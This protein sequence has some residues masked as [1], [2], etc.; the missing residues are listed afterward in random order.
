MQDQPNP[1][2]LYTNNYN[3]MNSTQN[4]NLT[5]SHVA[6]NN[7]SP[8]TP[9][10]PI[11]ASFDGLHHGGAQSEDDFW[12]F[13]D[14]LLSSLLD[15]RNLGQDDGGVCLM[16]QDGGRSGGE[17]ENHD[18]AGR[19]NSRLLEEGG[20]GVSLMDQILGQSDEGGGGANLMEQGG[21]GGGELENYNNVDHGKSGLLEG[22]SERNEKNKKRGVPRYNLAEIWPEDPDRAKRLLE[23]RQYMAR[24]R[25]KKVRYV[26]ELE[27]KAQ[28]LEFEATNLSAQLITY[29][30][31]K[32]GLT[33][34]NAELKVLLEVKQQQAELRDAISEALKQEVE[35]LK[36][37]NGGIQSPSDSFTF[38]TQPNSP[39]ASLSPLQSPMHYYKLLPSPSTLQANVQH[40]SLT[41]PS[42]LLPNVQHNSLTSPSTLQPPVQYKPLTS[43]SAL[44]SPLQS[45]PF[46]S[47]SGALHVV[48]HSPVASTSPFMLKIVSRSPAAS[49]SPRTRNNVFPLP[50]MSSAPLSQLSP[51]RDSGSSLLSRRGRPANLPTPPM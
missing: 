13:D 12:D 39:L 29:Q 5:T 46:A 51:L 20:G 17:L 50:K 26:S 34:E 30:R 10:P 47:P 9:T 1:Y 15:I 19:G 3:D 32:R 22:S 36:I 38:G 6:F 16:D 45:S 42:T 40:N 14:D 49:P 41:S 28:F 7:P 8:M 48:S 24:S 43:P 27:E 2:N 44:R 23:G 33:T 18:N 35:E 31:D 11:P 37:S 25:E 21:G 4:A